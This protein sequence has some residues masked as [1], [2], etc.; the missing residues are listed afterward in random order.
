MNHLID[1]NVLLAAS[2][3]VAEDLRDVTPKDTCERETVY[4][5][6]DAFVQSTAT[7][8]VDGPGKIIEEYNKKQSHQDFSLL[9]LLDKQSRNQ[10]LDVDVEYDRDNYAVLPERLSSVKWDNSDKM[11][12]AA[13][14][15]VVAYGEPVRIVNSSDTDW[16]DVANALVNENIGLLQLI[17][18]WCRAKYTEQNGREPPP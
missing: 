5:W 14:L 2:A 1:T 15:Q 6:L 3:Y 16:Y 11:F 12:V 13:G 10:V 4:L 9:A 7:W 18:P 17:D 8:V